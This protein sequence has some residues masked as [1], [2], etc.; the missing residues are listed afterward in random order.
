MSGVGIAV[1]T[2]KVLV[3]DDN[4]AKRYLLVRW[5]SQ[6]GFQVLE[7]TTGEEALAL[8]SE[9]PDLVV[10][11]V[12]LPDM[13]GFEVC[14]RL[15]NTPLTAH[16]PVLHVSAH[17]ASMNDRVI[18]LDGGADAYLTYPVEPEELIATARALLRVRSAEAALRESEERFRLVGC[19]TRDVVWDWDLRTNTLV[20][21]E[22][23]AT[24]FRLPNQEILGTAEWWYGRIHPDDRA[25]VVAGLHA[26]IDGAGEYWY[27]EYRVLRSDESYATVFDRGYV[28]HND[29]N[30]PARMVGSMLD[31]SERRRSEDARRFLGD[32]SALLATSLDYEATLKSVARLAVPRIADRC[33]V[34]IVDDAGLIRPLEVAAP[35]RE[36][37]ERLWDLQNRYPIN[38][39][40]STDTVARVI[41]G[42]TAEIVS[43]APT[44]HD[45][46]FEP[47]LIKPTSSSMVVPLRARGRTL[48]A[49]VLTSTS[50]ARAYEREQLLVAQELADRAALAVD[51]AKL[52][53]SAVLAN[54][55]KSDFLGVMSHELRTPLNAILG[56]SD[57]LLLGIAGPIGDDSKG[58]VDRVRTCAK[59]LLQLIEQILVFSRMETGKEP[60]VREPVALRPLITEVMTLVEPIA[61]EKGLAVHIGS[62]FPD[63]T[64]QSDR[65]KVNQIL[66]ALL[67]N[68]IKF[69]HAG[70]IGV[71]VRAEP[72]C[73]VIDVADSGIGISTENI[74]K[75][76]TPFWQVQQ[77]KTRTAGGTGLGLTVARRLA[78]LLH[79]DLNVSSRP[80]R[81]STFTLWLP[82]DFPQ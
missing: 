54:R 27:D 11:D 36:E 67:T 30:E 15:K 73:V 19:A 45:D 46:D 2:A 9:R 29:A 33:I 57:L 82:Y 58:Y 47:R 66:M 76:F 26:V 16:I 72:D 6:A 77:E 74:E 44:P 8:A 78:Q 37:E 43:G 12:K 10:L 55:T 3:A 70:T 23:A 51:N 39:D 56:Y 75:I 38:P 53:E 69:T 50:A 40:S 41:R 59:H 4:E 13:T 17:K 81:G 68:A 49:L 62:D 14:W 32:A 24:L 79:G 52:Y 22:A 20:W 7:A 5:L 42:G 18:G 63:V 61:T 1:S 65:T 80:S 64:I 48:G 71:E 60:L 34:Y 31:V 28:V 21:N 35:V 25:R